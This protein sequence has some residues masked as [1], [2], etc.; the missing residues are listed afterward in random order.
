[1]KIILKFLLENKREIMILLYSALSTIIVIKLCKLHI[2][3]TL[4]NILSVIFK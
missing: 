4:I 1:M 2:F 3:P